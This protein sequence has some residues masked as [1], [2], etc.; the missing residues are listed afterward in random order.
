MLYKQLPQRRDK[1]TSFERLSD[2]QIAFIINKDPYYT[3]EMIRRGH[4]F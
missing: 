3:T 4:E 1:K 2:T